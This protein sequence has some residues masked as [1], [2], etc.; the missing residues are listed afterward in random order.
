[1]TLAAGINK[2]AISD[3]NCLKNSINY[4]LKNY[5]KT[6]LKELGLVQLDPL[7]VKKFSL[8]KNPKS[9][10]NIDLT[11]SN[12]DLLGLGDA[13]VKKA[14]A[15]TVDLS[16]D[17]TFDMV[18]PRITLKG[19]YSIE[20]KVLIL[21]IQGKGDAQIELKRC[22]VHAVIKLKAVKKGPRQTIA[23][24]VDVKLD[25]DPSRVT[26]K[27]DGLFN[28]QKAQSDNFHALVNESWLEIF[29]ELKADISTATGLIFKSILNRTL[30]KLP[31]EQLFTGV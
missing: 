7:R 13:Q 12:A 23:E 31:L 3:E 1:M 10:V 30:S 24:V 20:G 2:C 9:P 15:F 18:S 26:Y 29:N 22:K 25:L 16:R 8:G 4:V 27:F 5:A 17:I 11:F 21:P 14:S 6:G 28:G 19:P